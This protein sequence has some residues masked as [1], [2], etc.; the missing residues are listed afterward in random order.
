MSNPADGSSDLIIVEGVC[1]AKDCEDGSKPVE[2]TCGDSARNPAGVSFKTFNNNCWTSHACLR[3]LTIVGL[4][5]GCQ[6]KI[7]CKK[8]NNNGWV[9]ARTSA[10][11]ETPC[12]GATVVWVHI[13]LGGAPKRATMA[14]T[15]SCEHAKTKG[16]PT[17]ISKTTQPNAQTSTPNP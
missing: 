5:F 2:H 6:H 1:N 10:R 14:E 12:I 13:V 16:C 11:E 15:R 9:T 3:T 7:P 17:S 8:R 4:L